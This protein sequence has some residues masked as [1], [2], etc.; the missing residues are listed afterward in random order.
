MVAASLPLTDAYVEMDICFVFQLRGNWL[1][2]ESLVTIPK[3]VYIDALSGAWMKSE[4]FLTTHTGVSRVLDQVA[5]SRR[6]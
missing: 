1:L 2:N 5:R 6:E 4:I 3:L